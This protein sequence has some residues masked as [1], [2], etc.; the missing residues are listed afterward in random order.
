MTVL[1]NGNDPLRKSRGDKGNKTL[2]KEKVTLGGRFLTVLLCQTRGSNRREQEQA[3]SSTERRS[4]HVCWPDGKVCVSLSSSQLMGSSLFPLCSHT[5]SSQGAA[6]PAMQAATEA[7][8]VTSCSII[9]LC[10]V[11]TILYGDS[12]PQTC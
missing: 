6:V 10:K 5:D 4:E 11:M 12:L 7:L 3:G 1:L 9:I 8:F 2:F